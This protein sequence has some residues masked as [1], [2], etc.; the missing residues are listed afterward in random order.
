MV[1]VSLALSACLGSDFADSLEGSWEMA[2][3]QH[4]GQPIEVLATHPIT[5]TFDDDRIGGRAAC[6]SYGGTYALAGASLEIADISWTEMACH[7]PEVMASE[8]TYL[9]SLGEIHNIEIDQ[10]G[11]VLTGPQ[12]TL[13]FVRLYP[14]PTADLVGTVWVL[15]SVVQGDTVMSVS[16]ERATLELYTDGSLIGST[17]CRDISGSYQV[18]GAEVQLTRFSA[19]G[20]CPDELTD[21]D[22]KIISALEGGFRVEIEGDRMTTWATGDEGL[23]YRADS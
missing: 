10:D 17:G 3:G 22:N 4:R 21:Q 8:A 23:V 7:P 13:T 1:G 15:D 14:V 5:L 12:T 6:N 2:S 20:E 11:L 19:A 18:F 16:G 9:I